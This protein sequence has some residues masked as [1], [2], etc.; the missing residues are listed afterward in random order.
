M[1]AE[2][3]E[4]HIIKRGEEF[5]LDFKTSHITAFKNGQS[6]ENEIYDTY[7]F[8]IS[9]SEVVSYNVNSHIVCG[10]NGGSSA[11]TF[12]LNDN[13]L[14]HLNKSFIVEVDYVPV[15]ASAIKLNFSQDYI[16]PYNIPTSDF[17]KIPVGN[18]FKVAAE[19]NDDA[20]D[21]RIQYVSSNPEIIQIDKET[22][23]GSAKKVGTAIITA[24]SLDNP[25]IFVKKE[26]K[27]TNSTSPFTLKFEGENIKYITSYNNDAKEFLGYNVGIYY[28]KTYK[29]KINPVFI[30][31]S[32]KFVVEHI[33]SSQ[34]DQTISIDSSGN[35]TTTA[36]GKT[37]VKIIY[38]EDDSL[39]KY[40]LIIN[41]E[42]IRDTIAF[43][44]LHTLIRKLFGHY[45]LFLCTA[46][47]GMI[48]ICL[49]YNTWLKKIIASL[50]YSVIGF[51]VAGGS[52]L[53]QMI[54]PNRG[55]SWKDVGIDF[56]GFMTT[57]GS[58]IVV[59]LIIWLISYLIKK[60]KGTA[61]KKEKII[62][63]NK[64]CKTS[65]QYEYEKRKIEKQQRKAKTKKK[66]K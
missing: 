6:I 62:V 59:F 20:T 51:A 12:V 37:T 34:K 46:L 63:V 52:E 16:D 5:Y 30:C 50:I 28:G 48:F 2:T 45:G 58:F 57:V 13:D 24:Y 7:S 1:Y 3:G 41:F 8:N 21:K 38:G 14:Q 33:E 27:V 17:S 36:L 10:I 43:N 66:K 25:D 54:T 53:I 42:V 35:I 9:D 18:D 4:P 39:Q 22:G 15:N 26:I 29:L 31:T 64:V 55:P 23:H 11:I 40:E 65:A 44:Q 61:P 56:G 60:H 49:T 32:D 47:T 19:V